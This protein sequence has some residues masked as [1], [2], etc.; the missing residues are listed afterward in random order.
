MKLKIYKKKG[1]M[2]LRI[3]IFVKKSHFCIPSYK[4]GVQKVNSRGDYL[5]KK[6]AQNT[7]ENT[8][9]VRL[10]YQTLPPD[11]SNVR[12]FYS[13][14][15]QFSPKHLFGDYFLLYLPYYLYFGCDQTKL[16]KIL[17]S[18]GG[19]MECLIESSLVGRA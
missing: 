3:S 9:G 11:S 6:C 4:S 18:R 13:H 12:Y 14:Y 5:V 2:G 19:Y 7:T 17:E 15:V 10:N 1:A 8:G 16:E